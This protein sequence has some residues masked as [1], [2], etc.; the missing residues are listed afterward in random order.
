[1]T[2]LEKNKY[3]WNNPIP[4]NM[5]LEIIDY[6]KN[7]K[8]QVYT[9]KQFG[10]SQCSVWRLLSK[11]NIK[12]IKIGSKVPL[13]IQKRIVSLYENG[14]T[15]KKISDAL[16][17][18]ISYNGVRD[19]LIRH[20]VVLKRKSLAGDKNPAAR[21]SPL[22][23]KDK[24]IVALYISGKTMRQIG[25]IYGV[26]FN[27]VRKVL[28]R[29][30]VKIRPIGHGKTG[31]N[32]PRWTGGKEARRKKDRKYIKQKMQQNPLFKLSMTLRMRIACFLR[33]HKLKKRNGTNRILGCDFPTVKEHLAKQFRDGM[34]WENHGR[35]WHVDHIIPLASAK[36]ENEIYRLMHYTNLQPLFVS[37]NLSKG[38]KLNW[39][40]WQ[41]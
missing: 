40:G 37:E 12:A 2:M 17:Y 14:V 36:N 30:D 11:H 33:R 4:H 3:G 15:I 1:M 24:E 21:S 20:N 29:N 22:Y 19:C 28:L 38:A 26:T 7:C 41:K 34:T 9:A 10:I 31:E 8:N 32:H 5:E 27:P 13:E 39:D 16:N 6:Y 35:V 23:G 25:D 18:D